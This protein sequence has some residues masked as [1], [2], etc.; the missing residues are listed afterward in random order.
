[1]NSRLEGIFAFADRLPKVNS[2]VT[3]GEGHTPL[4]EL[5]RLGEK[6]GVPGL[7]AKLEGF[8]PTGSY[9]DRIA[10]L[11]MSLALDQGLRGWV[12]T[13]SGNAG[14]SLAA[15]GVRAGLPG[16]VSVS[17]DIPREKL[18]PIL[19]SGTRVVRVEG[20]G[21]AGTAQAAGI[22]FAVIRD[23]ATVHRLF[24]GIT[25]HRFNPEGMRG[26]DTIGFELADSDLDIVV[27]PTGGG[28]LVT[29]IARGLADSGSVIRVVIAQPEGASPIV[30]Y[31]DDH[32]SEPR[33]D[34]CDSDVSGLQ[35]PDPPDG[36]LAAAAAR[37]SKGW[38]SATPDADIFEAQQLLAHTEGLLVEPASATSL[39][40]TIQDRRDGRIDPSD[41]VGLILTATGLKDL[42]SVERD[43]SPPP[44]VH[45]TA[46]D[47]ALTSWS[48]SFALSA[49]RDGDG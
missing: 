38:G 2:R 5:P 20:V 4:I 34:S 43:V 47:S 44:E 40:T 25:A 14:T 41:R 12:A 7:A 3:L 42:A 27:V 1:M 8:N 17:P 19:A 22:H 6:I 35:L 21:T 36:T 46:L 11:S 48:Q 31:L 23:F 30:Q 28:G 10:A 13:S 33:V 49:M 18:L 9:K 24:L 15:Y 37:R 32:I 45:P 26:A 16:F 29:A 39:A